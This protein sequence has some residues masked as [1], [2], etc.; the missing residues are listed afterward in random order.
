[1]DRN[2]TL[3]LEA[4]LYWKIASISVSIGRSAIGGAGLAMALAGLLLTVQQVF[5]SGVH[6]EAQI[7]SLLAILSITGAVIGATTRLFKLAP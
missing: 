7:S 5:S 3:W 1:M 6:D 4:P 2:Q